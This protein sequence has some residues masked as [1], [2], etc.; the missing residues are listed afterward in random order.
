M[1]AM[2]SDCL[3][4]IVNELTSANSYIAAIIQSYGMVK[5]VGRGQIDE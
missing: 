4:I 3:S 5:L 1:A 2:Y